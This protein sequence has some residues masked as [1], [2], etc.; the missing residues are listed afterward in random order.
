ML[1]DVEIK[2]IGEYEGDPFGDPQ[3]DRVWAIRRGKGLYES[4]MMEQYLDLLGRQKGL[5]HRNW[6]LS[7][8]YSCRIR[9]YF[10]KAS[11]LPDNVRAKKQDWEEM[12]RATR[13]A[14][15]EYGIADN[16]KQVLQKYSIIM[17]DPRP[18]VLSYYWR[19]KPEGYV[20]WKDPYGPW[21]GRKDGEYI[22]TFKHEDDMTEVVKWDLNEVPPELVI[23]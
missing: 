7:Q 10:D 15:A 8:P 11:A 13:M 16:I 12:M 23:Q 1:V 5:P 21:Y 9:D 6:R 19:V 14:G 2:P 3:S 18:F 17:R 4:V 20:S 22:G